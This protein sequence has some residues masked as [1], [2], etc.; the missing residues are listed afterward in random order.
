[1][2][3]IVVDA[4][5]AMKWLVPED[6]SEEAV[7]LLDGSFDLLAPDLLFPE[8]GN[9]LWKKVIRGELSAAEAQP[10]LAELARAPLLVVPSRPLLEVALPIALDT[11]RTV[12]DALYLAVAVLKDCALVTADERFARAL[13][14]GPLAKHVRALSGT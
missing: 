9:V 12:Y 1:M 10:I 14:G 3:A 11:R 7:R 4:S 2:T 13:E 6:L 8:C 5:V